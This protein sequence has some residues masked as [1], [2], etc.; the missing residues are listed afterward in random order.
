MTNVKPDLVLKLHFLVMSN[1]NIDFQSQDLQWRSYITKAI[2]P[3]IKQIKL[4]G[5][6]KFITAA[7]DSEYKAL[8]V[9]VA[10]FNINPVNEEYPSKKAQIAHLEA[11]EASIKVFSKYMYFIN[12][13]SLKLAVKL[14]KYT[15][16]NNH[17]I[18]FVDD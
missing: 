14:P 7:L 11:D 16:I 1:T 15:R 2:L 9:Y 17:T 12:I 13:F 10:V 8:I 5:K 18:E 6:K 4:I 3:I